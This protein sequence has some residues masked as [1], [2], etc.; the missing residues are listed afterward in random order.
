MIKVPA[1][2]RLIVPALLLL[3]APASA[4]GV[5]ASQVSCVLQPS[6]H[7][8]LSSAVPGIVRSVRVE[9]GDR[10]RKGQPLLE[11]TSDVE[12]AQAQLARTKAEL[13]RRKLSRNQDAIRKHLLSDMESDQIE[14]EARAGQQEYE[15]ARRT[16][17]Q[18][19]TFSPINGIVVNRK[20]EPGQYVG[21]D[22]VFELVGLDPLHAELVF[23]VDAFGKLKPGMPVAIT[24][25]APVSR[26]V[27]GEVAIV[28][29]VIDA[30]SGTFGVRVK[31]PNPD[32]AIP[33]GVS[34]RTNID[35][36]AP[37]R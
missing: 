37:K 19:T 4:A 29:R 13:A 17:D 1:M 16:A 3:A 24:L 25:G 6:Q 15:V 32:F 23:K 30:R 5:D 8:M 20:A 33:S 7:L 35:G 9:R 36:T 12:D 34:C 11:L 14:S 27:R 10:V 31:I 18:K 21:T 22:P 2:K 28:D 26:D